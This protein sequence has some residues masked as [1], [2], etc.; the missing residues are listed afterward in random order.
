M[1]A[2]KMAILAGDGVDP[3]ARRALAETTGADT[4]APAYVRALAQVALGEAPDVSVMLAAGDAFARTGLALA[5]LARGDA[6]AYAA[7]L[8]EILA[9]FES[10][11]QHLSGVA[12]ADTVAVLER[13][14]AARG[15][16]ARPTSDILRA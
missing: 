10:R 13:L 16:A 1:G 14:A 3:I 6:G 7:A 5:A 9:D 11:D 15:I 12:F 8:G 2:L 4:P